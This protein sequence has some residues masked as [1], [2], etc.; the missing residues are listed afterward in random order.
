MN[1]KACPGWKEAALVRIEVTRG[2]NSFIK[3]VRLNTIRQ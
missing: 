1:L 3:A 2:E